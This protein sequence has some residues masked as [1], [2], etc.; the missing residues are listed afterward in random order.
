[1]EPTEAQEASEVA[2]HKAKSA[3]LAIEIAR[4]LQQ[5][6]LV[7]KTAERSKEMMI[8]GLQEVFG[9]GDTKDPK[10]MKVLWSRIPLL[11]TQMEVVHTDISEIKGDVREMKEDKKRTAE[12][13][14]EVKDTIKWA[15]RIII[16]A[17]ILGIL[18]IT[19]FP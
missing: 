13:I 9:T 19:V 11:C 12:D 14:K 15:T 2:A 7:E 6:E 16:G 3:Q 17:V 5:K 18:K 4:E 10:Q 8:E 1:M